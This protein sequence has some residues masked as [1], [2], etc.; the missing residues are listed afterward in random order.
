[1]QENEDNMFNKTII[2]LIFAICLFVF[3]F[4]VSYAIKIQSYDEF[5][6]INS[7]LSK[8]STLACGLELSYGTL[9]ADDNTAIFKLPSLNS[10]KVII[11]GAYDYCTAVMQGR[12]LMLSIIPSENSLRKHVTIYYKNLPEIVFNTSGNFI[13]LNCKI[14]NTLYQSFFTVNPSVIHVPDNPEVLK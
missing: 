4:F 12:L 5:M 14:N 8:A 11:Q 1:M 2:S 3:V 6:K 7:K 13:E 10:S 9:F